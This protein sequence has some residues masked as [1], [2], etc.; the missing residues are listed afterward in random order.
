MRAGWLAGW[1]AGWRAGGT[2]FAEQIKRKSLVLKFPKQ[3]MENKK[4]KKAG[5]TIHCDYL[6][7]PR[8]SSN[9]RRTDPVVT[10]STIFEQVLNEMRDMP[11][12]HPFLYPVN[13][14]IVPDYFTIVKEPM[15]LQTI[16]EHIRAKKYQNREDFLL[17]VNL[18]LKNSTLYN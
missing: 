4:R 16:R 9:R 13:A 12:T 1:L 14:K 15:D 6:K 11:N 17:D 5:S 10:M 3:A 7:K 8:Q 2:S 18:I